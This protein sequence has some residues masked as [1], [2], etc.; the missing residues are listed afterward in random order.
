MKEITTIGLD[1]A[2]QIFQVHAADVEGA[3]VISRKL[4]RADVLSFF[5]KTPRCLVGLEACGGAHYQL[6]PWTGVRRFG[7]LRGTRAP[8]AQGMRARSARKSSRTR[9]RAGRG[10][11][12]PR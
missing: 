8:S 12:C 6:G 5:R 4:R 11:P 1:L 10:P 2:K 7:R 9:M 3:P